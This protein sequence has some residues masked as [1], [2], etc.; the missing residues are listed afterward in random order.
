MFVEGDNLDDLSLSPKRFIA[1]DG[2]L[3]TSIYNDLCLVSVIF[4]IGILLA[5]KQL[6]STWILLLF[7]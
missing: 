6:Q 5:R 1:K 4:P 2:I 7:P 3:P